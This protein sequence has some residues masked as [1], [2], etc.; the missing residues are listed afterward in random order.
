VYLALGDKQKTLDFYNQALAT[1]RQAGTP[2]QV[3]WTLYE[4]GDLHSGLG[5][6][7]KALDSFDQALP[8]F[9]QA[10]DRNGEATNAF[11]MQETT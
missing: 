8:I 10:G 3:A 9:H 5:E 7:Q 2:A 6:K 1:F 4:I 11:Q